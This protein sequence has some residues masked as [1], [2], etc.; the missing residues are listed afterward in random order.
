MKIRAHW[1]AMIVGLGLAAL[2]LPALHR[3]SAVSV[4]PQDK[5]TVKFGKQPWWNLELVEASNTTYTLRAK[6]GAALSAA[7]FGL[8]GVG[9]TSYEL[10][11]NT[12]LTQ[13]A[14]NT[15]WGS[16]TN[17]D[18]HLYASWAETSGKSTSDTSPSTDISAS[19][20]TNF[21]VAVDGNPV[22]SVTLT[23]ALLSS[24]TAIAAGL[25]SGINAALLAAGQGSTVAAAFT[26]SLYVIT[27]NLKGVKSKVV[28]TD[29]TTLNVADNLKIGVANSGVEVT[30]TRGPQ[31]CVSDK[32][33]LTTVG[34]TAIGAA[35]YMSCTATLPST[36]VVRQVAYADLNCTGPVIGTLRE[37]AFAEG[38][39]LLPMS[40]YGSVAST[41]TGT[42][43]DFA[44]PG[45]GT[46]TKCSVTPVSWGTGPTFMKTA[47]TAA[48][49]ITVGVDTAQASGTSTISY[50]CW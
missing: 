37:Q 4:E 17:R 23:N 36:T 31:L 2:S 6:N 28:V 8:M 38:A 3:A 1:L 29:G 50:V 11:A 42:A 24:G 22:V 43:I 10:G 40:K 45:I 19:T 49:K 48:D 13:G 18:V 20:D 41:A 39:G 35:G 32:S 27:S 26:S 21:K 9:G 16:A 5:D 34:S 14:C 12:T 44:V 25:Q 15:L 30:G 7:N 46:A 33:G 47:I